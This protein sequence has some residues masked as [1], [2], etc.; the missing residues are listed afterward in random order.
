MNDLSLNFLLSAEYDLTTAEYMLK[1]KRYVYVVFM[2]HMAIE[3]TLKS[4]IAEMLG[5]IPPR[6]HNL[7]YLLKKADLKL[8][9][10]LLEFIAKINNASVITRYPDDFQNLVESYPESVAQEYLLNTKEVIIWLKRKM[11]SKK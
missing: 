9:E 7:L 5:E 6:T 8:P 11:K 3:K 4:F 2:S 1:T 10:N